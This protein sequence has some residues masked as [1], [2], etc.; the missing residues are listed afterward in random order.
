MRDS[1]LTGMSIGGG[2]GIYEV[3]VNGF[4]GADWYR[5]VFIG[6]FCTVIYAVYNSFKPRKGR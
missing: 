1:L 3:L 6:I 4:S 2:V 5:A